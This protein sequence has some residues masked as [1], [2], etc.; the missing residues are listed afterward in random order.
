MP[1]S[2]CVYSPSCVPFVRLLRNTQSKIL[3]S[4]ALCWENIL[5]KTAVRKIWL[6]LKCAWPICN[7]HNLHYRF[8]H[9]RYSVVSIL[10]LNI[11]G[12]DW[13]YL[14]NWYITEVVA[15]AVLAKIWLAMSLW[16]P[17]QKTG[18]A[19]LVIGIWIWKMWCSNEIVP[20]I[21]TGHLSGFDQYNTLWNKPERLEACIVWLT[22]SLSSQYVVSRAPLLVSKIPAGKW[23]L[24]CF[25]VVVF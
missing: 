17:C 16:R 11:Y 7:N 13:R 12:R 25:S 14:E 23:D 10:T 6:C 1:A 22:S 19:A 24:W 5:A 8:L 18:E 21:V 15:A 3:T 9:I 4:K 20:W 2:C